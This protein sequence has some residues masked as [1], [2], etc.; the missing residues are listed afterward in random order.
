MAVTPRK[1]KDQPQ[2]CKQDQGKVAASL[3]LTAMVGSALYLYWKKSEQIKPD[4]SKPDQSKPD[5]IKPDQAPNSR[6]YIVESF[7]SAMGESIGDVMQQA[8]ELVDSASLEHSVHIDSEEG[9]GVGQ[10]EVHCGFGDHTDGGSAEEE[11]QAQIR[12]LKTYMKKELS[13]Q[14]I[15]WKREHPGHQRDH[16]E[17]FLLENYPENVTADAEG[18]VLWVDPRVQGQAWLGAFES[19]SALHSLFELGPPPMAS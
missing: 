17:L 15:L 3:A 1:R 5:Q 7:A 2:R 13:N 4:Q 18:R 14:M 19:T 8:Q 10:Q 12:E 6:T 11:E 16:F 9:C